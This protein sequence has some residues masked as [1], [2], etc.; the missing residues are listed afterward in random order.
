MNQT[1]RLVRPRAPGT[2][3]AVV[4]ALATAGVELGEERQ[5]HSKAEGTALAS[6]RHWA[7]R[8]LRAF[9]LDTPLDTP[10]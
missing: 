5:Y 7:S 1:R 2:I 6:A 9:L 10:S 4:N 3:T 8:A